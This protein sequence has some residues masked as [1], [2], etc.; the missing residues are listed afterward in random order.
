MGGHRHN[1]VAGIHQLRTPMTVKWQ[2]VPLLE[3]SAMS[4]DRLGQ[5][6][7]SFD[8]L[9]DGN[10]SLACSRHILSYCSECAV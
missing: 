10:N 7:E 3:I 6:F 5:V 2:D 1:P 4:D 8:I 9:A